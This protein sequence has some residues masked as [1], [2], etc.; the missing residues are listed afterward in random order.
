MEMTLREAPALLWEVV[1]GL[2]ACCWRT[3]WNLSKSSL[4]PHGAGVWGGADPFQKAP[5]RPAG[6]NGAQEVTVVVERVKGKISPE[7]SGRAVEA[8]CVRL[9]ASQLNSPEPLGVQT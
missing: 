1:R 9:E 2:C 8:Q 5:L 7:R 6:W 3:Y 4:S